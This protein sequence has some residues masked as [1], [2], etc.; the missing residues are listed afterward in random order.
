MVSLIRRNTTFEKIKPHP[1]STYGPRKITNAVDVSDIA[2]VASWVNTSKGDLA[3]GRILWEIT[4]NAVLM[5]EP[6]ANDLV[7]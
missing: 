1:N 4:V 6:D 7:R 5:L 3:S 2:R